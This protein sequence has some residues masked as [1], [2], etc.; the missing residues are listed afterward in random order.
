MHLDDEQVQRLLHGELAAQAH[1]SARGHL[2]ACAEC[3]SRLTE[4]EREEAWVLDRLRRLDHTPP[5]VSV[6]TLMNVPSHRARAWGRL[7]AGIFLALAGVGV[8][9]ATPGSPLPRVLDRLIHWIGA[10]PERQTPPAPSRRAGES[11]AGIAVAPGDGLTI[12][13][14]SGQPDDTAVVSLTDGREV[15]V[16]AIGGMTTFTSDAERLVIDHHGP[17]A[18]FEILIPRSA[19]SVQLLVGDRQV[20]VKKASSIVSDTRPGAPGRY[21]VPLSRSP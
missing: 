8:A 4:A 5:R 19:P 17:A 1:A 11:Q 2:E 18:R 9:Y 14:L 15:V 21:V 10:A 20:F 3:R 6:R 12:V 7:A 13:F 16:R